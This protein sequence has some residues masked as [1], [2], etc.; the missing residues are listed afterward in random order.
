MKEI[1][2]KDLDWYVLEEKEGKTKLLLKNVL[3]EE[4]IKKYCEDDWYRNG[5]EVRHSDCIRPPFV[6]ENSYI[7]KVILPNFL[8]DLDVDGEVT[9][10]TKEEVES[11]PNEVK[12]CDYWYWT[13]SDATDDNDDYAYAW[14]VVTD[15]NLSSNGCVNNTYAVRPVFYLE[16]SV[17]CSGDA[18]P[19]NLLN[20]D[21]KEVCKNKV[22]EISKKLEDNCPKTELVKR[23]NKLTEIMKI[24]VG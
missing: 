17:L 5:K 19:E 12:C 16:S 21:V 15:G 10:L 2:F 3:D 8:K 9:L 4:R 20:E 14:L 24:L 11:L 23:V 22:A 1:K 18:N 6:W 7:Y 13:K